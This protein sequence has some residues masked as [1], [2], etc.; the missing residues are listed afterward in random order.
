MKFMLAMLL[1][2]SLAAAGSEGPYFPW[3]NFIGGLMLYIFS[4]L[5]WRV[6]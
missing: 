6:A 4:R 3:P 5:A 2:L 1:L